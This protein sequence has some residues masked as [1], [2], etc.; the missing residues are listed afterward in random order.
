MPD[1]FLR[2]AVD[3]SASPLTV[4]SLQAAFAEL[5]E[6]AWEPHRH[7]F[8]PGCRSTDGVWVCVDCGAPVEF[9]GGV[10]VG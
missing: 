4:A 9:R 10:P 2:S 3:D 6:Q 7:L 5:W 1:G 8:H